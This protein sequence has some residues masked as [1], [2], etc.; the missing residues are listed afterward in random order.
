V[1]RLVAVSSPPSGIYRLARGPGDPF[2]PPD[3]ERADADGTFGNRFDDPSAED[4]VLPA[5]RF[6]TIYCATQRTAAFG[7]TMARFRPSVALLAHLGA[8]D[9]DEPLERALAGAV[10]PVDL[11]RGLVP[12]DWR[13]RRRVGHT[14]L[15]PSLRFVDLAAGE[16]MQ[17]LRTALAPMAKQ[18]SVVDIDLSVVTGPQRRLTQEIA[19][20]V[21]DQRDRNGRPRFAGIRYLSRLNAEWECWAVFDDRMRHVAGCPDFPSTVLPDDADLIQVSRQFNLTVE[22]FARQGMYLRP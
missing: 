2:A 15:D 14:V 6:R 10:D 11:R 7:E 13:V 20:F 21:H 18:L 1:A 5:K 4:G 12:A 22:V 9:D 3:W 17:R 8:I 16:T 19:R